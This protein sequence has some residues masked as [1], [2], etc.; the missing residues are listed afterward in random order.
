MM[1][2][3]S[4][5]GNFVFRRRTRKTTL[6]LGAVVACISALLLLYSQTMSF[7][8]DEGFHILTAQLIDRGETPYIDFCFPQTPLNAYWNAAWMAIF[9]QSWRVTHVLAA[10]LVSA[11]VFLIADYVFRFFPVQRWNVAAAVAVAF[12]VG[13]NTIVFEFGTVAQAYGIGLFLTVAAFRAGVAAVGR[14]GWVISLLA[15]LLV[16]AAAG[17]SLLTAPMVPVLLLWM[18]VCNRAGNRWT[19]LVASLVGTVVPFIPVITLF[20]K[21]PRQVFFNIVQYQAI[22]RRVKWTGASAHDVDVLSAWLVD[23][24]SLLLGLL[25]LAGLVFVTKS[26]NWGRIRRREFYLCAW[27]AG[28]SILYISTAHPTFQRYF[29]FVIP[30]V[31]VLATAG[32]YWAGSRLN[33]PERP[34]WPALIVS[35]LFALSLARAIFDD[36]D[37]TTWKDYEEI[38]K[39]VDQVTPAHGSLYADEMVYFLTRRPPPSGMEFS[40]AHKLDLP[41]A[42][43]ALYHVVSE[44]EL[45]AQIKA[46]KYD[47]VQSCNDDRIDEMNLVNLFANKVDIKDCSIFWGKLKSA[48]AAAP[49]PKSK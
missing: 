11:A 8:W 3:Q 25:A 12:F 21:A 14:S 13:L 28:A 22:F 24:Q 35:V 2:E 29:I 27:L 46:G 15:G 42:Q 43:E 23:A 7:V 26:S 19:K 31:S 33:S 16:G 48:P 6:L 9:G 47:T 38:S 39:K 45:D 44:S 34:F 5:S 41:P 40:Y 32:M 30:F 20:L 49:K 36:R 10:L 1:E 37:S 18:L 4:G 17:C